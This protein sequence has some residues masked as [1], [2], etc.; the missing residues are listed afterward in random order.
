MSRL[1]QSL[2]L[3]PTDGTVSLPGLVSVG[4]DSLPATSI[5]EHVAMQEAALLS[6]NSKHDACSIDYIFFRR[7]A[8]GRSSQ[9]AAYVVDNSHNRYS[10][11]ALADLH[12]RVWLNGVAPL[13]Y[14]EWPTHIDI[15]RCAAG[16][17]EFW[18]EVKET[19]VY[20][21]AETIKTATEVSSALDERQIRRFSATRLA[22]GTFWEDPRNEDWACAD[23]SAHK[24]LIKS[25]IDLDKTLLQKVGA[26]MHPIVRRLLLLFI[27]TK[28][29]E[30]RGVFPDGWFRKHSDGADSFLEVLKSNRIDDVSRVISDL[31]NRFNGDLF[32]LPPIEKSL[33]PEVFREFVSLL[34]GKTINRQKYLWRQYSFRHVPVEVL[35]HLYQHFAQTGKGAIY[36]PPFVADLLLDHALPYERMTG[37]ERVLDPTCG[38]G[39]FLVGAFRRLVHHWKS[40]NDWKSPDVGLLKDLLR[41]CIF[42]VEDLKE[43][44]DVA[45]L[46]LALAVCDALVPEVIWDKLRFDKLLGKNVFVGD[47]FENIHN[48][49]E[50][51]V[52]G[53]SC[54]I[55]NP[56]FLS[57]LTEAAKGTEVEAF[58]DIPTPDG[59][60][61]YQVLITAMTLLSHSGKLCLI[62]PSGLLYNTNPRDFSARF[63]ASHT[64]ESVLDFVSIRSL[65]ENADTKAVALVAL[66]PSP[67]P[68]HVIQHLTF[69]RTKSVQERLGFELDHYDFH[70]INQDQATHCPWVW[71]GNLLGG[72][73]LIGLI[74]KMMK[75]PTLGDF[76]SQKGWTMGEG[77]IV[78]KDEKKKKEVEWLENKP[79]L[80]T[81]ALTENG[82]DRELI[83]VVPDHRVVYASK[84]ERFRAPMFLIAENA[85]LNSAMWTDGDLTFGHRIISICP[86]Q[87]DS[88]N[89]AKFS[90]AFQQQKERLIQFGLI[91]SSE[92]LIGQS[93]SILRK[94]IAELPWVEEGCINKFSW[95]ED[96]LLS[97]ATSVYAPMIRVGENSDGIKYGVN[98]EQMKAYADSFV[99]LMGSVYKNLRPGSGGV[100]EDGMAYQSFIFGE[101]S[102]VDWPGDWSTHLKSILHKQRADVLSTSRILRFYEGNTLFIVK[103][104]RMRNWIASTAIRDADETLIDLVKQ[105]F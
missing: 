5:A 90:I 102:N 86:K 64:V 83:T 43:A 29:L 103:P 41:Q 96:A 80:P 27:F 45:T 42:G 94:D 85:T 2:H 67:A 72:G 33:S 101:T 104:D 28:Y 20:R 47:F 12:Y 100:S 99:K 87:Q 50:A 44:A 76:V 31:K 77:F 97:D 54:I 89:L 82:I 88:E 3:A 69:R 35:S 11:D 53:F 79:F 51:C 40:Q 105:G 71:K 14:V 58:A 56:P 74:D 8:D 65:F 17:D 6:W 46:N 23:R 81:S 30:D 7:F 59:Q 26:E 62:Q 38:S 63:F 70:M 95:W 55:G 1:L 92:A 49:R 75:W 48:L 52:G 13:L 34:E 57:A 18:T 10:R 66:K 4:N 36:T 15:L 68:D 24:L 98:Q 22:N 16:P 78:G 9:V 93:S 21:A 19:C 32:E 25:T 60:I 37:N 73:R 39:V 91:R 84:P 61:A